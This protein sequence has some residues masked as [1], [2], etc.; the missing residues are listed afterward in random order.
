MAILSKHKIMMQ[1]LD[2]AYDK[3]LHSSGA[4]ENAYQLANE[5]L[6]KEKDPHGAAMGLVKWQTAKCA[7]AGFLTGLGGLITMPITVP[8]NI[9][10]VLFLQLRMIAA[11]AILGGHDP[12]SDQV[13]SLA[14]ICLT[15]SAAFDIMKG[16]GIRIGEKI[17]ENALRK[18]SSEVIVKINERV[19][20]RLLSRFGRSGVVS[21]SKAVPIVGG[22]ISGTFDATSTKVI[23]R[24][25]VRSFIPTA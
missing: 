7:T 8:A 4:I 2:W 14:I 6:E 11:I 10:S 9:T 1:A 17:T 5:Y 3:A 22:I 20:F 16:V 18:I 19:G 24:T 21:L 12:K 15:G 23:G 13:K 25:A